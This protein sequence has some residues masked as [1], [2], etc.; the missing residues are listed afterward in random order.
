MP[1]SGGEESLGEF[2]AKTMRG[3]GPYADEMREKRAHVGI[4][5][6]GEHL[7]CLTCGMPWPCLTYRRLG[8]DV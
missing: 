1:E 5:P 8:R 4:K 3:E 2:V 7:E 6:D